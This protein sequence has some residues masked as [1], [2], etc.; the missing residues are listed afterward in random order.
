MKT[1]ANLKGAEF[2]RATYNIVEE[3]EKF[4]NATGLMAIWKK[5]PTYTGE[6]TEEE[7]LAIMREQVKKNW[8]EMLKSALHTNAE[9]TYSFVMALF[10]L[11]DGEGEPDGMEMLMGA[12]DLIADERVI[13]FFTKLLKSGVLDITA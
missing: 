6:E 13:A 2:F 9:A 10:V 12:L 5:R 3:V 8:R 11:E 1:I 7:K 4:N